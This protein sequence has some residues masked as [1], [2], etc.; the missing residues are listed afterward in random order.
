METLHLTG[1]PTLEDIL[2]ST[3]PSPYWIHQLGNP[4]N[5]RLAKHKLSDTGLAPK[6]LMAEEED[7]TRKD[8][9]KECPHPHL[10][11]ELLCPC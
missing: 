7:S 1:M 9:R 6:E 3:V 2:L 4:K 5:A 10:R 11:L 8:S